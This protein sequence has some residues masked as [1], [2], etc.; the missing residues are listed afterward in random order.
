MTV[1]KSDYY[2]IG[3]SVVFILVAFLNIG[4]VQTF[5]GL[6]WY[7]FVFDAFWVSIPCKN[8]MHV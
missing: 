7:E 8:L 3:I 2:R 5:K 4:K 1:L 6:F